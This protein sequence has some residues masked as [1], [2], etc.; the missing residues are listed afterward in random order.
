MIVL[1]T[2]AAIELLLALPLA[3]QVQQHL[4]AQNW[5][6]AAPQLL[7][8]E[9]LQVLRRRVQ[10][11]Y[12]SIEEAEQAISIFSDLGIRLF[13]HAPLLARIWRL[14]DTV[15]AYDAA[16]VALAE[17]LDVPLL[18]ADARLAHAPGHGAVVQLVAPVN[19]ASGA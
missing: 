15:T 19:R 10:A 17:G 1:D 12:N 5:Q 18:T 8:I 2:S 14:R 9:I 6:I 16:F 13:D 4:E 11:G 7:S 3:G